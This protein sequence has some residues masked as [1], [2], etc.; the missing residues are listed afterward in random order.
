MK[1]SYQCV[2]SPTPY[3]RPCMMLLGVR[4]PAAS[5]LVET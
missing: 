3:I 1:R 5:A 4:Y 2:T